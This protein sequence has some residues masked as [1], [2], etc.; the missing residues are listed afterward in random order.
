MYFK[1]RTLKGPWRIWY[2]AVSVCVAQHLQAGG[3]W[4][5]T[6]MCSRPVDTRKH[7]CQPI[8]Q[9]GPL[10]AQELHACACWAT[11][12]TRAACGCACRPNSPLPS[13]SRAV[14]LQRLRTAA[15]KNR[16]DNRRGSIL[17]Q[18]ANTPQPSLPQLSPRHSLKIARILSQEQLFGIKRAIVKVWGRLW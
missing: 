14:K 17:Y 1:K 9:A 10:L 11:T 8:I 3:W 6:R 12:C 18:M 4:T 2:R 16:D 5:L 7:A 13:P 15:L